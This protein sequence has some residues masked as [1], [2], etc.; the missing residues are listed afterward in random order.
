MI[1]FFPLGF[2]DPLPIALGWREEN[3]Q[4]RCVQARS[5]SLLSVK[6]KNPD[7]WMASENWFIYCWW[8]EVGISVTLQSSLKQ[9]FC[10]HV[11]LISQTC[12]KILHLHTQV[13][14]SRGRDGKKP[15]SVKEGV[16]PD[17]SQG[18]KFLLHL[19][20]G[21]WNLWWQFGSRE[22]VNPTPA[23]LS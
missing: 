3:S 20:V 5:F 16:K 15:N 19:I 7:L 2:P 8:G 18:N 1:L 12:W 11:Q 10:D 9:G 22:S 4:G 13:L 14:Y 6:V 21:Q 17:Q 23:A